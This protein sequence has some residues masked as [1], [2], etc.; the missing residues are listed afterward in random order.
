MKYIIK[1]LKTFSLLSI[2]YKK[3]SETKFKNQIWNVIETRFNNKFKKQFS[4]SAQI[5]A[6]DI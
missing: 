4:Q 1:K 5:Y 2:F 6:K 3:K